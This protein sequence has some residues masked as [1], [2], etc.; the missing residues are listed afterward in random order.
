MNENIENK[1]IEFEDWMYGRNFSAS[2]IEDAVRKIRF[3]SKSIDLENRESVHEFLKEARRMGATKQKINGYIKYLNR[4]ILF[5]G[6]DTFEYIPGTKKKFTINRYDANEVKLL[7]ERSKGETLE[8]NRDHTM[9]ILALNTGLRASEIANLKVK[10]IH[11]NYLTVE[12]GKGEE[13]R[14]VYLDS[15]TFESIRKWLPL[16]NHQNLN[17]VFTTRKG[18]I[19]SS[20]MENLSKRIRERTGVKG[21][22]WHRCRHTYAVKLVMEN[23]DLQ[24]ISQMLGHERLDTTAIY[25]K[26][27][28]AEA[29]RRMHDQNPKLFKEDKMFKSPKSYDIVNVLAGI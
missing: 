16:R 22:K 27:D 11:E 25:T 13:N 8:D 15:F 21:F 24:T 6:W 7:L 2:T 5:R 9:I 28:S 26:L 20:Y 1:L 10:D 14:D 4:W 3:F 17:Y 19:T 18:K 29:I 12:R 23:M